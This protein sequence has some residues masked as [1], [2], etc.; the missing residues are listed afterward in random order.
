[1]KKLLLVLILLPVSMLSQE[2]AIR[3]ISGTVS[4][5]FSP[6][7]NVT[8]NVNNSEEVA[9]S[10]KDGRYR[11]KAAAGD[12]LV[13]TYTG[14]KTVRIQLED[15]TRVLNVTLYQEIQE[16]NEVV[17]TKSNRKSQ[18]EL[19]M[20]YNSNKRLIKTAWG[21]L[22][23]DTAPGQIYM[24]NE[25]SIMPIG[26]CILDVLRNEFPGVQVSG[27]CRIGGSVVIRGRNSMFLSSGAVYDI[28]GQIFVNTPLWLDVN[29]IKR[30]AILGNF[31]TT[32]KYGG[33]GTGGVVVI[34]TIS[35]NAFPKN[36][37][38]Y[39]R[40][41]NNFY[42]NDALN[43]EQVLLNAP[44]YLQELQNTKTFDEAQE[45]FENFA[46]RYGQS[47]YFLIDA[48]HFFTKN[49][50]N[51]D[52]GIAIYK[53]NQRLFDDNAMHLKSVAYAFEAAGLHEEAH[54]IYKKVFIL[55]PNY[56]QSYIDL[57]NS[58]RVLKESKMAATMFT[59]YNYLVDEG[60]M[61]K[62]ITSLST[63]MDREYNNLLSLMGDEVVG[64]RSSELFVEAED[65]EGTRLVFEWSDG[66]AEFD[67]QFVNPQNQYEIW[68]HGLEK[69]AERIANEKAGG[70]S[71][72][73]YLIDGS[74]RG[75]W[76]INVL[77]LGNKKLTPS[78]LKAT[79]YH[80]YGSAAQRKEVQ[81]FKLSLT[82][83]NQKLFTISNTNSVVSN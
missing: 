33:L 6:L 46:G 82:D 28:D 49:W 16:L 26:I 51:E 76:Q 78:Y 36:N 70:F 30:I 41:K 75:T 10:D 83:V 48:I 20:E 14:K 52:F 19:A 65:F 50:P 73:E 56:A 62:D 24:L 77:Y 45:V 7:Q 8:I 27:D 66:E 15:V 54:E 29:N 63:M 22:D 67:L 17:V 69:N 35:G 61:D 21:I 64:K 12:E 11:I 72:Q 4:D 23:A 43:F 71:M 47:Q 9:V 1:M 2:A 57:A 68:H 44:V 37:I 55:R 5:E 74:I 18:E 31:P 60:F 38:D 40:L 79:I 58:Y 34:N 80:D 42:N 3:T 32:V 53:N 39:A 25:D 13:F 59:R 81:L